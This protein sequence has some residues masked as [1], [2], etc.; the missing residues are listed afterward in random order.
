MFKGEH[1]EF[2]ESEAALEVDAPSQEQC[3]QEIKLRGPFSPL[4]TRV[5]VLTE[6]GSSKDASIDGHSVNSVLL[7]SN[8]QV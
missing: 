7:D 6:A 3:R 1:N 5:Y 2:L 8:P 4:E